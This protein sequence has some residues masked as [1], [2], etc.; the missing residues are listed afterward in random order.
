[1]KFG[2]YDISR[3]RSCNIYYRIN[4]S[5]TGMTDSIKD[6]MQGDTGIFVSLQSD[7]KVGI[8]VISSDL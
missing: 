2:H 6:Y 3:Y 1:M 5:N 8:I 7:R 4:M